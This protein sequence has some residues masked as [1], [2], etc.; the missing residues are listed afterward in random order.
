M[1][2]IKEDKDIR[3]AKVFDG[4]RCTNRTHAFEVQTQQATTTSIWH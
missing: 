1:E 4:A 2:D 3:T